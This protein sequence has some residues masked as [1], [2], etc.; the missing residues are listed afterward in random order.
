[1]SERWKAMP[2]F[3]QDL[4]AQV[5]DTLGDEE[6]EPIACCP[7]MEDAETVANAL[8][9]YTAKVQKEDKP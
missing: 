7:T 5:V 1:M 6:S 4:D 9:A 3:R 8:N 2:L